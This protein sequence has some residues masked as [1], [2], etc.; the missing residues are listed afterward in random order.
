MRYLSFLILLAASMSCGE[1]TISQNGVNVGTDADPPVDDPSWDQ[2]TGITTDAGGTPTADTDTPQTDMGDG[3]A[4]MPLTPP[5]MGSVDMFVCDNSLCGVGASCVNNACTCDDGLLGD[6]YERCSEANPCADVNCPDG[7][8]CNPDGS[9]GCDPFFADDGDGGCTPQ[10]PVADLTTRS[11]A[12]VCAIWQDDYARSSNETFLI[13][14]VA[15]C[16]PGVLH[17]EEMREAL[18]RTSIY[19]LLVGLYPVSLAAGQR[20]RVQECAVMMDANNALS[21][22]PPTSWA[23][24]TD[25]GAAGAG[26]SNIALGVGTAAGTVGLYIQDPGTPS[27]GHRRWIFNPRMARTAFGHLGRGGCMYS[28]DGGRSHNVDFVAYPSAG[29]FPQAAVAGKWSISGGASYQDSDTVEIMNMSDNSMVTVSNIT[30][31]SFGNLASTLSWAVS[32]PPTGVDLQV[33]I[34]DDQA[35]LKQQYVTRLVNCP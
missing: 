31:P 10:A 1:L 12:D 18:H 27:L 33:T 28:F 34:R 22:D 23:C 24:Y 7:A 17:P 14:P 6:P 5:D 35:A 3:T 19:R 15:A 21:H 13:D 8:S 9:C 11:A 25:V 32:S 26:S 16:D 20:D 4:D 2:D 30:A 29:P